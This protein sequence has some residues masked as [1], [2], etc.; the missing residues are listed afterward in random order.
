MTNTTPQKVRF[1][2]IGAGFSG[3]AV[4]IRLREEGISD[5]VV[6]ERA[7]EV[8]GA[9]RDNTYPGAACD[10]ESHLYSYSF[11]PKKDWSRVFAA[12]PEILDY[13]KSVVADF[14]LSQHIRLGQELLEARWDQESQRWLVR[15]T[16]EFYSAEILISG[17]GALSDPAIPSLTGLEDFTGETWHSSQWRH[18]IDLTGK[19]V[20]VIGTG[21]SAIQF[22]PEIQPTVDNLRVFQRTPAWVLSR[23]DRPY[24]PLQKRVF[25]TVPVAQQLNRQRIYAEREALAFLEQRPRLIKPVQN[26]AKRHLES[27][28]TDPTLREKLTPSYTLGCKR[29]LISNDWY[30]ALTQ[31]NVDVVTDGIDRITPEGVLTTDG[32]LHEMDYIIFGTGFQ[33]TT[34]P[35]AHRIVGRAGHSLAQQWGG[36]MRAYRNT[37]VNGFPNM[38]IINGPNV[39]SG[40]TSMIYMIE[41]QV[42][43]LIKALRAMQSHGADVLEVTEV[44][45]QR[46]AT[47]MQERGTGTVWTAGGCSSWYLDEHGRNTLIWPGHSFSFRALVSTFDAGHYDLTSTVR[48]GDLATVS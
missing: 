30:P 22:V 35:V 15:T 18:D 37:S 31:P 6:L 45:E 46:F 38:F 1:A 43:Y 3:V 12:Q 33:A 21:A 23:H 13:I 47:W 41:A 5:F 40:H 10:V 42:D 19:R 24:S 34:P 8:G 32:H 17:T 4:S 29:I 9:W 16:S 11:A 25:S 20:A 7:E 27:Q 48:D 2:I 26:M 36:S 28:V 14:D 44:E 39:G